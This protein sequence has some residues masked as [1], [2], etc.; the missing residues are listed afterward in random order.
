MI[1]QELEAGDLVLDQGHVRPYGLHVS[2][3]INY[4]LTGTFPKVYKG[5]DGLRPERIG[6]GMAFEDVMELAFA[7]A[8][9]T[10][11]RPDPIFVPVEFLHPVLKLVVKSGIWVS[12][13]GFDPTVLCVE[14]FKLTW[15]SSSKTFPH[16]KVYSSWHWQVMS[17]C[18]ALGV[19]DARYW[20]MYV[21]SDYKPP[22]PHKPRV[23]A[24]RYSP[25]ELQ[26]NWT[27]LVQHAMTG[28]LFDP[29]LQIGD[30]HAET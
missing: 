13:D 11:F 5:A 8:S 2:S 23:F 10:T 1:C 19:F 22:K 26:E 18:L 14:E 17:Y 7:S 20:V 4:M 25:L 9:Q 21:N 27:M 28:N 30:T 24:V 15:Y 3:I 29:Y 6:M 16:D 12:P